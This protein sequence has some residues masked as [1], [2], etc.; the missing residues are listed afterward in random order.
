M[1]RLARTMA[2]QAWPHPPA[3]QAHRREAHFRRRFLVAGMLPLVVAVMLVVAGTMDVVAQDVYS[4]ETLRISRKLQCPV[5]AGQSVADSNSQLARQMRDI[6][7]QKV[8]AGETEEQIIAYFVARYGDS[9][10][11]EPPKSGI[12]LGLWLMPVAAVG[13]GVAVVGLYLMERTQRMPSPARLS[14][15]AEVVTRDD[16]E[17]EAIA[18]DIL[19]PSG[20]ERTLG[21]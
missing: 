21:A 8:Q 10:V 7:E 12:G 15:S 19:G 14:D 3:I 5:C 13:L 17:L 18:R 1:R 2:Q 16:Q 11:T 4:T 20:S 6:I 9:I